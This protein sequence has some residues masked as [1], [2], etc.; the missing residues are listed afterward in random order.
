[1]GSFQ[2]HDN[3]DKLKRDFAEIEQLSEMLNED[4]LKPTEVTSPAEELAD[5]EKKETS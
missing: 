3:L 5:K 2:P 4:V 1:M